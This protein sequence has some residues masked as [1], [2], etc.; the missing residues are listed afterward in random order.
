MWLA[1]QTGEAAGMG[2][3]AVFLLPPNDWCP[4]GKTAYIGCMYTAPVFRRQGVASRLLEF[5]LA[6]LKEQGCG[7]IMLHAT[8]MGRPL[9]EKFGFEVSPSSMALYP[10]GTYRL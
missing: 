2:G 1:E 7:H 5:L 10:F 4:G 9:Y 6:E 3:A 8:D